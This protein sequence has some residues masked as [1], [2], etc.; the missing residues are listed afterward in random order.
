[1]VTPASLLDAALK[2]AENA[3]APYSQFRVGAALLLENGAIVTGC[4]QE[5]AAYPL[6]LCA[7]RVALGNA[8]SQD[9]KTRVTTVAVASPDAKNLLT[10]CGACRQVISEIAMRQNTD[11]KVVMLKPSGEIITRTISELLPLAFVL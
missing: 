2:A 10:P 1:M 7:E 4:N 11:I 5:N 8:L 9:P 3:Y 6:A